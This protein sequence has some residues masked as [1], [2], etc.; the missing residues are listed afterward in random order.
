M[1]LYML[2]GIGY[3]FAAAAQPG[4]FQTYLISQTLIKGW[5]RSLPAAF[6]PLLSD[7]PIIAL[8]LL[9]LSQLPPWFQRFL[10]MAGG[11]FVLYL[12]YGAY[13]SWKNFHPNLPYIETETRQ[14]FLQAALINALNPNPYIF[15]SLVTGP[16]LVNGWRE[17]PLYG[18][19]FITTF[20]VT[21]ILGFSTLIIIF[22]S[23]R[24]LGSRVNHMLL[25][26]SAAA[27]FCFGLY[28]IG[29]GIDI[30]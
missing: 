16:I 24:Q 25:G 12:S 1:W 3:G 26:I 2:Q 30:S 22:G 17:T 19:A 7:G 21:M 11:L 27:S 23:A 14:S 4:P 9:I 5:K 18:V 10:Y 20:Y 28:Q 29:L 15:W 6:A 8:S 13:K